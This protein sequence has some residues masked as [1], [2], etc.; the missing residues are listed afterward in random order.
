MPYDLL[1]GFTPQVQ[2]HKQDSEVPELGRRK[3]WL[4]SA[5]VKAMAAMRG[6]QELW[7]RRT[8]QKKGGRHYQ[9]FKQGDQVW[10]KGVNLKS[11]HPCAKLAAR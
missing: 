3:E 4:E 5:R 8:A 1:I 11:I 9:G 2:V 6:A 10:L 7:K